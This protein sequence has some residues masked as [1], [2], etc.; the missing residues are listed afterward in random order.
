M[1][2]RF[3]DQVCQC[4]SLLKLSNPSFQYPFVIRKCNSMVSK[5]I[6]TVEYEGSVLYQINILPNKLR[7][8]GSLFIISLEFGECLFLWSYLGSLLQL[9]SAG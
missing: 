6:T 5:L 9:H 4:H 1:E 2:T 8:N 3:L 7:L